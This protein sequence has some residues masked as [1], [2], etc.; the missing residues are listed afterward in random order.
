MQAYLFGGEGAR[1]R[2]QQGVKVLD[3]M[4]N[5]WSELVLPSDGKKGPESRTALAATAYQ[6]R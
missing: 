6:D 3:L 2:L 4:T 5:E 1:L